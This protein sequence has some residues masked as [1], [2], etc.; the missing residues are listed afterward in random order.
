MRS[1]SIAVD[2]DE[3]K[4]DAILSNVD[5]CHQPGAA[6]GIAIDGRPVYRKGFGLASMELPIALSPTIRMRIG[7]VSKHFTALAYLLLCEEGRAGIDDPIVRHLPELHP[8]CHR[9]TMRQLMSNTSGLRDVCAVKLDFSGIETWPVTSED[10]L[11]LYRD[12]DDVNAAPDTTWIYNN[13]GWII[14]S[15]AIERIDGES[16]EQ[17]LRTRIFE[18]I[19]MRDTLL[20]RWD[21]DIAPNSAASHMSRQGGGLMRANYGMDNFAG[22]GAISSTADDMLLWLAHMDAPTVGNDSTWKAM[23][24]SH[25][26]LNGTATGYGLGVFVS[27]YRGASVIHHAGGGCG[28][29]AQ[30]LKVPAAALDISITANCDTV[31]APSLA[32]SILDACLPTFTP[33][34]E[35]TYPRLSTGVFQS[36]ASGRV[37]Q[38]STEHRR[39]RVSIDGA[40]EPAELDDD[41]R[42][43]P[44][45]TL[46][47]SKRFLTLKGD[48]E[49]PASIELNDFGNIDHL[50]SLQPAIDPGIAAI[51]GTYRAHTIGTEAR[52]FEAEAGPRLRT[53]GRF[54]MA[55]FTLE[56]LASNVWRAR[57]TGPRAQYGGILSFDSQNGFQFSNASLRSLPFRR[58]WM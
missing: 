55:E 22:G 6:V 45:P 47:H 39:Q 50:T 44:A 30:M 40:H 32:R 43:W 27:E 14:L 15:A 37:I 58:I 4:I 46:G 53:I 26:L 12:I 21:T 52:I 41:G 10:L 24:T 8:S 3:K 7:S 28:C 36:P 51:A 31:S 48:P 16:L 11:S 34:K 18:P 1:D 23:L 56:C 38:L 19:G 33:V 35:T 5:Q 2:F 42:L 25:V 20:R 57:T 54:G 17:V 29:N 9:V 49:R 13:G